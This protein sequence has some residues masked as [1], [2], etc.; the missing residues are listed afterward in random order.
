MVS[1][2]VVKNNGRRYTE[3][4]YNQQGR[5][6]NFLYDLVFKQGLI[7]ATML[8]IYTFYLKYNKTLYFFQNDAGL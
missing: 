8:Q 5:S 2:T 4:K 6:Y 3:C 1:Q 7:F